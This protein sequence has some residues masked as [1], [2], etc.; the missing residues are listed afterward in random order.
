MMELTT[1][2]KKILNKEEETQR[3]IKKEIAE[4]ERKVKGLRAKHKIQHIK[5]RL[6]ELNAQLE[7]SERKVLKIKWP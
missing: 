5:E 1:K 6:L 4:L 7:L 3:T 2:Q